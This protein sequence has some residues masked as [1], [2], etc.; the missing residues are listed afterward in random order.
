MVAARKAEGKKREQPAEGCHEARLLS[1]TDLGHQ[2]AW[3]W[4]GKEIEDAWKLELTYEL[5]KHFM[6]DGRPFVVSEEITNKDWEDSKTSKYSTL[7]ARAR[8]LL[9]K[10]YR[11]GVDDLVKLLDCP[12]MVNVN[13]NEKGYAKLKGQAAV[14]SVAFGME[15]LELTNTPYF[16]HMDSPDLDLWEA[17]P[18]FKKEKIQKSL[19]YP[20]SALATE[21]AAGDKY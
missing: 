20:D 1:I 2:P 13:I 7:V 15:V 8:S 5:V 18:D 4:Q 19:N 10:D 17:M 12:C 14:G 21:L 3:N 9:G 11:A 16:F 6:A